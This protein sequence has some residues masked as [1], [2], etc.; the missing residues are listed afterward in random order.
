MNARLAEKV[1]A[2]LDVADEFAIPIVSPRAENQ[3][4]GIV[5]LEPD[6]DHLTVLAAAL[7][8]HGVTATM[9]DGT[10]RLSAHVST[11]ADSLSLLRSALLSFATA[12]AAR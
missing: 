12:S 5:V 10:V 11:D 6:A 9:R 7:H 4:A 1:S 3:R 2:V 8:N